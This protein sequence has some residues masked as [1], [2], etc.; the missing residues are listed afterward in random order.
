VLARDRQC[1][2]NLGSDLDALLL[3]ES[4]EHLNETVRECVQ[5]D[6]EFAFCKALVWGGLEDMW[7]QSHAQ[8]RCASSSPH[9][10]CREPSAPPVA[11]RP[12]LASE[13]HRPVDP[14]QRSCRRHPSSS[15]E[16]HLGQRRCVSSRRWH[17]QG[18]DHC[19][20]A[21]RGEESRA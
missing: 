2:C 17:H 14:C 16:L 15:W 9:S 3:G 18:Q 12:R 19:F 13:D 20:G 5:V 1:W 11:S 4:P 8:H 10:C 21:F 6:M 7:R